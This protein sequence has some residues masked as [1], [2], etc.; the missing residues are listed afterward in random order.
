MAERSARSITRRHRTGW[1][2]PAQGKALP[3][4]LMTLSL[5]ALL[6][7]SLALGS[8]SIPPGQILTVLL[9]GEA[10][11]PAWTQIVLKIRLPKT[12]TAMLS[13]MALGVSGLLMQTW[14]RNPLAEP[15][16]LGVSAGAS[17]GVALVVLTA[18]AAGGAMLSGI[19]IGGDLL[20]TGAAGLGSA[21]TMALAL[22][23]ALRVRSSLTLLI[24]GLMYGYMV[25][26]LVS[27]LLY[28]ARP[29]R[30]QAYINWT[31]GSFSGVALARIPIL[32]IVVV[33]GLLLA[34]SLVKPLNALL[35]GE[36]YARSMGVH[37][38]RGA[39]GPG[40][41]GGPAGQPGHGLLRSHR[42]HRHR[43]AASVPRLA[44]LVGSPGS[45]AS[46]L[47]DWRC[48]GA[49]RVPAGGAAGQQPGPAAEC[50]DGLA[51]RAGRDPGDSAAIPGRNMMAM[52][53]QT[54]AL[55]IGYRRRRQPD[56]VLASQLNLRLRPGTLV[57]L[58]GVNGVGK[59]T[60]LQTLAGTQA[61]LAGSVL[62]AGR[63][64]RQ[65]GAGDL[66]RRLSMVLTRSPSAV[67]MT[68]F[69]LVALGRLPH[70]DWL[71][72][73]RADDRRMVAW[74]LEAV[75]AR[76]LANESVAEL[77]DGQRQKLMIAR[78][79]AQETEVMLLDEPTA[80]LDLPRRIETM[81]LPEGSGA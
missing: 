31:F 79:L 47:P 13:G 18:G 12:L 72:K 43:R 80:F 10:D 5:C 46:H 50:C 28:F 30:I 64:L 19:G 36:A 75:D 70:T 27:L 76:D 37:L 67:A 73:L 68:G 52:A 45:A 33:A 40:V 1:P 62:L 77:S 6:A 2:S 34:A 41:S 32:T 48:G 7:L 29:E 16:V 49:G 81:Q 17:L 78:A 38:G 21:A 44:A 60:L 58:L 69:E 20:V 4:A 57:G 15:Y 42:L 8:V 55:T 66:A 39:A 61:P 74:A 22:L 51:G 14:F 56:I 53:L 65:L 9:G 26:A 3:L 24:L 35:L 63:D 71:G 25:S 54:R 11:Q 59:S 23:V